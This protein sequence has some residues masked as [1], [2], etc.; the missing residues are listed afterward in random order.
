VDNVRRDARVAG[1]L[2]QCSRDAIDG[3]A[4]VGPGVVVLRDA[5][6]PAAVVRGVVAVVVNAIKGVSF[7][8]SRPHVRKEPR[9]VMSPF[10]ADRHPAA[11]VVLGV[12]GSQ[13]SVASAQHSMPDPVFGRVRE[14]VRGVQRPSACARDLRTQTSTTARVIGSQLGSIDIGDSTAVAAAEPARRFALVGRESSDDQTS[15]PLACQVYKSAHI[16][17]ITPNGRLLP[18]PQGIGA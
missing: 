6:G 12:L 8:R 2:G 17:S 11:A 15:K 14:A 1:P 3:N 13:R 18:S 9:E 5:G 4:P 10:R 16:I 7:R